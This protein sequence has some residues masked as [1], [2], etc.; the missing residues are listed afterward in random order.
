[1]QTSW[2]N[3]L[4]FTYAV[5]YAPKQVKNPSSVPSAL[6]KDKNDQAQLRH[7][8]EVHE[9]TPIS[10]LPGAF[11]PYF[12][13][14]EG[15]AIPIVN[16]YRGASAFLIGGGPS[17]KEVDKEPLRSV[18]TMTLNNSPTTFRPNANCVVDDPSRFSLS[19]WL[20]PTIMKFAP[21][22]HFEK[23][24]WDNRLLKT[25]DGEK[26]MWEKSHLRVGDCPNIVGYRRNEKFHAPRWLYEDTINWGNH[27]KY[28]GGRSVML[29]AIRI[30]FLLG[31]R[32]VYLL[33][34]DFDMTSEKR[35]HFEESRSPNAVK[36]NNSTYQKMIKWFSELQPFFLREDFLVRNCNKHSKLATFPHIEFEAAIQEALAIRGDFKHERTVDMYNPA[37]R[38]STL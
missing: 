2:R 35:Y 34:V 31:F 19:I 37:D 11:H 16:S 18:W 13:T 8:R 30:L 15:A 9:G 36:G 21:M 27:K 26:Q 38:K 10:R 23:P 28:G 24:L 25:P 12:F 17:F 32:R 33:G 6:L 1:L 7:G 20:D 29:A 22:S 14:R 4:D 3:H 5:G